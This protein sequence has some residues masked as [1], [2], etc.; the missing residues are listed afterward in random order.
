MIGWSGITLSGSRFM[1]GL[2]SG[3]GR[4]LPWMGSYFATFG[5]SYGASQELSRDW[6]EW[7]IDRD[8][9]FRQQ[10]EYGQYNYADFDEYYDPYAVEQYYG[11]MSGFG[12]G[13][14]PA[15]GIDFG[16]SYY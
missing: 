5:Q 14:S 1:S 6:L 13:V 2:A 4:S 11:A 7:N 16:Y 3:L 10:R 9:W 8:L 12:R 15:Y